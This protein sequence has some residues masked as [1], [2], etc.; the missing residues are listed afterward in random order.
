MEKSDWSKSIPLKEQFQIVKRMFYYAKPYK[1][2]FFIAI[3]WG[4]CLAVIN[5][6]LPKILQVFMDDYLT[7]KTA[8]SQVILTFAALY[9]GVTLVKIVVWFLQMYLYQMATEKTVQN[10]RNQL[11]EKLHT[12]GMRYFDQ[13]PA[14][15]IV[16]RVTNDTETIK[17]F[18]GVY[19]TV[20]QGLFA[21]VSAFTAMFLLNRTIA[22]WCL[23]FLPVLLV[24]VWYYQ[25]FS[26]KVYRGMREKLSQLNTKLN[27]S[28]SGMSIIQQFRQEK[29]LQKEFNETNESYYRSRVAMVKTNALLLGPII[30]LLYTFSLAVVLG[31]FGY[32]ALKEPVSVGVIYAF[33]SYVQSFFNPMTNMMDNL[34][35]FQDGM[36]SSGRVLRI[37]DNQELS[38]AQSEQA[39]ETIQD[40]KIEFKDVS[41]SYDG[42]HNVLHHISFTANPGE[43]VAL[44]G[45]TGSGKSSIINVMMRFYEFY[46]GDILI[47][48]KSIK[49]YPI[50]ELR[51]KM[52]LVLQDSFLFYGNI[53]NNIRLMNPLISDAAIEDAARFVQADTFINQLP[54]DCESKV[55]ERGASYSSG[56]KQLISFARTIVT[57]PKILVLDEATANIDTETETLI[58]EGL[59]KMRKGR[60]TIAIAHRLSTIRDA[61][62]ILV[63]DHGEIVERGSHDELIDLGGI[64]YD[65][66]RLQNSEE[67]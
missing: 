62:L 12:L 19:L 55:I 59:K 58:Q 24:I 29:R 45:H 15:S 3:F 5:V 35:I 38:P 22:L 21:I 40:A 27:E 31:F 56:Q 1:K 8:T 9:F 16:S 13:T 44:V 47:D 14:G 26:S 25:R 4:A 10:I 49:N 50:T 51:Q 46:E 64:Y 34:S 20:L 39:A 17:D 53:K 65:M 23:L 7:T 6:M 2:Q 54:N 33:I 37:M 63:L 52:G 43:T 57:D 60:T 41:F 11:F 67:S 30:N 28:I 36:V 48:G 18:W 61:N 32:D 42:E 66:Y